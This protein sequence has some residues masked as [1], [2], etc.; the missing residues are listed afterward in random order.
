MCENVSFERPPTNMHTTFCSIAAA[1]D[2]RHWRL[3]GIDLGVLK[4][5]VPDSAPSLHA[6]QLSGDLPAG[7]GWV[8]AGGQ[9]CR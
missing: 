2:G 4:A 8:L 6:L 3:S 5:A 1:G 9:V 7:L